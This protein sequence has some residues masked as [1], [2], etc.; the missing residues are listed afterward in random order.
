MQKIYEVR[1]LIQTSVADSQMRLDPYGAMRIFQDMTELHSL[2]LGIDAFSMRE[3]SGAFW[4]VTKMHIRFVRTPKEFEQA[5]VRTWPQAAVHASCPR[6]YT[7]ETPSGALV[8]AKSEWVLLDTEKR[9]IRRPESTCYPADFDFCADTVL[10]EPFLRL[11]PDFAKMDKCMTRTILSSD[12]D[13][14]AHT[15]NCQ[16]AR[17]VLDCFPSA[18][19][20]ENEV[21]DF[22]LHFLNESRE[23][24][25]LTLYGSG[26]PDGRMLVAGANGQGKAVFAAA[27]RLRKAQA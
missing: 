7:L 21:E 16:Y 9:S 15:N 5:L 25:I 19:W 1:R 22:E 26:L 8:Q 12:L 20:K 27:L 23:G 13:M 6:Y 24:E 4:V 11:R 2:D 10:D 18:F 17:F 3:K 14:S